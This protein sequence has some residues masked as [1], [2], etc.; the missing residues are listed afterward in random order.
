MKKDE[1]DID[2]ETMDYNYDFPEFHINIKK[3]LGFID[4]DD[5]SEFSQYIPVIN[6]LMDEGYDAKQIAEMTMLD[7]K[8]VEEYTS[9]ILPVM[10]QKNKILQMYNIEHKDPAVIIGSLG[11]SWPALIIVDKLIMSWIENGEIPLNL[12]STPKKKFITAE[13]TSENKRN[14]IKITKG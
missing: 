7:P 3:L 5:G 8:E 12:D 1:R 2:Y 10:L 13:A 6:K 9:I 4:P 11:I 14:H